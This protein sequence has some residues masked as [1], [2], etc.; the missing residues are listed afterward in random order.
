MMGGL[1]GG[2]R[3]ME[4]EVSKPKNLTATL[5]R[6][7]EYFSRYWY[8]LVIS[9][10]LI[11]AS[12]WTQVA[13]PDIIGQAVDCYFF[14]RVESCWYTTV[15]PAMP[16]ET[17]LAGLGALTLILV[18]LFIA[19]AIFGGLS[20]F[21][22]SWTGQNVLRKMRQDLFA[23]I[24]R[25]SLGFYAEREVGDIM[26]RI[27]SDTDT[28]QQAFSFALLNVIGG[29]LLIGWIIIKMLEANVPYALVSL[30]VVPVMAVATVYFSNQ[31]RKAF[32]RSREQMGSVNADLQESIA[33]VRET[34][35]FNREEE[36]ID[37]FRRTNAANRDVNVRAAAFTSALTPV[38]EALG[39]V[40]IGVVVVAGGLSVL[41]N[42]PLLGTTI[43][44]LGTV[45]AFLQY[46]QRFNQ[47]IQQ[48]AVLWTNIQSAIAGGE[49]I[50]GLLDEQADIVDKPGAKDIPS[51]KGHVQFDN[52]TAEYVQGEPVLNGVS[53]EAQPGQ[54]VA[55]VGPTG[56][57]KTTIIN[58]IPRFYDVTS[59]AV[60]IDGFDVRNVT[61]ASLRSQIGIVLQ[62]SFLFSDTVMNNIRYGWLGATDEDVIAAARLVAAD[63]FIERLPQGYQTILGERGSGLSQGQRQLISIARAALMSPHIL[64]LDEAT[65]SVDTRTERVIQKAFETLL[66]GRTS[67]VI[68]HRLSTIRN[69]DQVLMLRGGEIIE[70]GTH[71]SLL[72]QRGAYYELYMSQF[73]HE[74]ETDAPSTNGA[75][76]E[77]APA[78]ETKQM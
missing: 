48:I 6:F 2:R 69:A 44:S 36:N 32:R 11:V 4:G 67:F 23:Q 52:V 38:L 75:S 29:V 72:A 35:A 17:K 74:E 39:Y 70:R 78:K 33:G 25:L 16:L 57:G 12:T 76:G 63:T 66:E 41:R 73:R 47:P 68:A 18:G 40:A 77:H 58:L 34:Q 21:M 27:T 49:R 20:F 15:D 54:T 5:G 65:S 51:I 43:I 37:Q 64:I 9:L 10:V 60:R 42:E 7:G 22:M 26:S 55:I 53:F 71:N 3:F 14:P 19:G 62:D 24:H 61:A 13:A 8:G 46:V 50:F 56:A 30:A 1:D 31:A 28:I 59:G 45:F